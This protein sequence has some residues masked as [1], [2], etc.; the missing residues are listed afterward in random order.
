MYIQS[1]NNLKE[2]YT[3]VAK[4]LRRKIKGYSQFIKDFSNGYVV[5]PDCLLA[6]SLLG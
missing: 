6:I 4:E 5:H 2:T 1:D 3:K